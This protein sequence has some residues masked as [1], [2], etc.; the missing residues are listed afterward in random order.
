MGDTEVYDIVKVFEFT[1][2]RKMMSIV[3][4]HRESNSLYIL[5]KG[6]S[7]QMST[8]LSVQ[9]SNDPTA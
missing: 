8:K 1:S 9:A 7:D 3:M 4:R 2:E 5:A 6:A